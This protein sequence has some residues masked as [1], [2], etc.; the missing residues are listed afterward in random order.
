MR[1]ICKPRT[2]AARRCKHRQLTELPATAPQATEDLIKELKDDKK[3]LQEEKK[4]LEAAAAV[5]ERRRVHDTAEANSSAGFLQSSLDQ[6]AAWREEEKK[7]KAGEATPCKPIATHAWCQEHARASCAHFRELMEKSEEHEQKQTR[8]ISALETDMIRDKAGRSDIHARM[9]SLSLS[10]SA[11]RFCFSVSCF[12]CHEAALK[13]LRSK[14]ESEM[15][16]TAEL[17]MSEAA[18]DGT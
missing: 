1:R 8:L 13:D 3:G 2:R 12:S 10:L 16:R 5:A 18:T 9:T 7:E 4:K 15:T 6:M 11:T 17:L 14:L